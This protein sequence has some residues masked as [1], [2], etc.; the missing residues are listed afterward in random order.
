[1]ALY[2]CAEDQDNLKSER[3]EDCFGT[4]TLFLL[5]KHQ[6]SAFL[7]LGSPNALIRAEC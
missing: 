6:G 3:T 2:A 4:L 1:M 7:K 5:L